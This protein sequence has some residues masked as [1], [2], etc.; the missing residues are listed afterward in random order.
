M[1]G[2]RSRDMV[3]DEGWTGAEIEKC[4]DIA[5]RLGCGLD[6]AARYIVPVAQVDPEGIERL[7]R[8]AHGRYISASRAGPYRMEDAKADAPSA[9]RR[10]EV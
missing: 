1:P 8:Q 2:L 5:D 4:V 6:Q 7:R 9:G 10:M 3:N